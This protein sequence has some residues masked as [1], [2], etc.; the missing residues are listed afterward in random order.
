[1]IQDL[2]LLLISQKISAVRNLDFTIVLDE[3]RIVEKGT[4]TELLDLAGIY[5]G[6]FKRQ[7]ITQ[8]EWEYLERIG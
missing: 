4:H 6:L 7:Q 5:A 2:T 8:E 1:M 3:G